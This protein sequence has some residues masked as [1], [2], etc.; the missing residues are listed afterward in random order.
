MSPIPTGY[1]NEPVAKDEFSWINSLPKGLT[2]WVGDIE[3]WM[4]KGGIYTTKTKCR[5]PMIL[6]DFTRQT[7]IE[8]DCHV[9]PTQKASKTNYDLI[10]SKDFMQEFGVDL[11][12]SSLTLLRWN[13]KSYAQF[14][15]TQETLVS[16]L[17]G[18]VLIW[19]HDLSSYE[20]IQIGI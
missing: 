5:V 18:L 14:R 3:Q 1:C 6:P 12:N 7:K 19:G 11:L 2:K 17:P 10:L 4:S 16:S 13:R 15:K 20:D 9:D 8:F